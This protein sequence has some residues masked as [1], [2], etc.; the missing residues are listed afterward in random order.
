MVKVLNLTV[1]TPIYLVLTTKN[2][3]PS[4]SYKVVSSRKM[5]QTTQKKITIHGEGKVKL[6]EH[7]EHNLAK[8]Y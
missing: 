6:G 4:N 5:N 7:W 1:L 2:Q 3:N 8:Y